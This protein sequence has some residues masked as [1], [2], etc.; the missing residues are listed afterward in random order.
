MHLLISNFVTDRLVPCRLY[1]GRTY[2]W[3]ETS[4][5]YP[6]G[7]TSLIYTLKPFERQ[8]YFHYLN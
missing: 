7:V 6:N 5:G 8:K 1:T 2:L 3:Q 4:L